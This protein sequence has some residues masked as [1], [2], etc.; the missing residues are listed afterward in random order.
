M[1]AGDN[2]ALWH[3]LND[4]QST[5]LFPIIYAAWDSARTAGSSR[6]VPSAPSVRRRL[7]RSAISSRYVTS[8]RLSLAE[9]GA[10]GEAVT[11]AGMGEA[12]IKARMGEA[13]IKAKRSSSANS[14]GKAVADPAAP[15]AGVD[16]AEPE[17]G[18]VPIIG[19]VPVVG[20]VGVARRHTAIVWIVV[21]SGIAGVRGGRRL[22]SRRRRT[23]Q[24]CRS[25][26][27]GGCRVL[28]VRI[29][30]A[31]Q[32]ER[33]RDGVGGRGMRGSCFGDR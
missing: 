29:R 31:A 11:K 2:Q 25:S 1:R 9:P 21:E 28:F 27:I 13:V 15:A 32:Y 20:G 7:A 23:A 4:F 14:V 26:A 8:R 6:S 17:T 24:H 30:G 19:P 12:V 33:R 3:L 22:H 18:P 16:P 10:M 5:I